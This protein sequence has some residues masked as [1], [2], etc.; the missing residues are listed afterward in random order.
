MASEKYL[1]VA[2]GEISLISGLIFTTVM[3]ALLPSGLSWTDVE[4]SSISADTS[5]MF[6]LQWGIIFAISALVVAQH[7]VRMLSN[8]LANRFLLVMLAYCA[9][10]AIWSPV[11]ISTFTKVIQ[12]SGL[13]LFCLAVQTSRRPWMHFLPVILAAV[14]LVEFASAVIAIVY[15]SLGMDAEFTTSWRGVTAGKNVLG[16]VGALGILL[17]LAHQRAKNFRS[18]AFWSGFGLSLLCLVMSKSSSS[19]IATVFGVFSF[20]IL[21]KN[22]IQSPLWFQRIV[23]SVSI[24]LLLLAHLFFVLEGHLPSQNELLD[25]LAGLFGKDS[26]L[27]GRTAIWALLEIEIQ[28]HFFFGIGYGAFWLGPG[29]AAQSILDKLNWV[30]SQGHNG[31]LDILNELGTVGIILFL[32]FIITIIRGLHQLIYIDRQAT[33]LFASMLITFLFFNMSESTL[34]RGVHIHF[35]LT[36][37]ISVSMTTALSQPESRE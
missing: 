33:A 28:K 34:F 31:Y 6:R 23:V 20:W 12:F 25:P 16:R 32:G 15:P 9:A 8:L 22:R 36:I 18:V 1:D 4:S 2:K 30:P 11:P 7:R 24:A 13:V 26:D 14:T 19:I 37:L 17:W 35:L 3:V 10:S 5:I 27:T 29:S 21:L